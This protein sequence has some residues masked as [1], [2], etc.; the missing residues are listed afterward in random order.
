[1]FF[2]FFYYLLQWTWGLLQNLVGLIFFLLAKKD[3]VRNYFAAVQ[4]LYAGDSRL[5]GFGSFALGIFI[6]MPAN[7]SEESGK[8][9][10]AHE[11]GHTIQSMIYGPLYLPLVGLFSISW[12]LRYRRSSQKFNRKN[13]YYCSRYPEKQANKWGEKI[14]GQKG[15]DW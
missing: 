3:R 10:L 12:A 2:Y 4:T 7:Y 11:Y 5:F 6:F 13:I 14:A 9:I 1:M 15:I 8:K